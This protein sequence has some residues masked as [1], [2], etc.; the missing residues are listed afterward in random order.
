MKAR[1]GGSDQEGELH[2][3]LETCNLY[4]GLRE[5]GRKMDTKENCKGMCDRN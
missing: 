2:L 1:V 5:G 4:E 3:L